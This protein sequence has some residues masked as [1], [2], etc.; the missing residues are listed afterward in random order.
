MT[1]Q[2]L[3]VSKVTVNKTLSDLD[4][5][6]RIVE[7]FRRLNDGGT[8]LS[9]FDLVASILKGFSWEMEGFL[10]ETLEE[11]QDIGLTQENLI[12]LSLF[13]NP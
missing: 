5:R 9:S 3:G 13:Q 1:F 2:T 8:R 10:R 11:Y 4:N 7:L 12:R 6:Q